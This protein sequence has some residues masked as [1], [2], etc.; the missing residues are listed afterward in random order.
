MK[1][2][3][4]NQIQQLISQN[5]INNVNQYPSF[6]EIKSS[7]CLENFPTYESIYPY[8]NNKDPKEIHISYQKD[9]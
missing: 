8:S 2:L 3:N 1:N 7:I 5:N 6:D 9:N 4:P